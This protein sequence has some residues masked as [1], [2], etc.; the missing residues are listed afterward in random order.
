MI[1]QIRV[2]SN[3]SDVGSES[4]LIRRPAFLPA[5]LQDSLTADA[6]RR[7]NCGR[8]GYLASPGLKLELAVA[9]K[10]A[11]SIVWLIARVIQVSLDARLQM[12]S[13]LGNLSS[14]SFG[15]GSK[16]TGNPKMACPGKWRHG[17]NLRNPSCLSLC[18]TPLGGK[19]MTHLNSFILA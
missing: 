6:S 15:C 10:T 18:H 7:T 3:I 8:S 16:K 2:K 9:R 1:F 11:R 12:L 14:C 13:F 4:A 19:C 5:A 17:P